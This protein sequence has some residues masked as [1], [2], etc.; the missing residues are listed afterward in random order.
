M[1]KNSEVGMRN[2]EV[3]GMRNAEVFEFGLDELSAG[4]REQ[5]DQHLIE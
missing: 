3:G 2:V 4:C 5:S 1:K